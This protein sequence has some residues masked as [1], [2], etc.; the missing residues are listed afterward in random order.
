MGARKPIIHRGGNLA[1]KVHSIDLS[2]ESFTAY[3]WGERNAQTVLLAHATGFHARCWDGVVEHLPA[4]LNVIAIDARGH[5][6]STNAQPIE[7]HQFALDCVA[8]AKH[9]GVQG[10]IGVG[11][12]MGG[13]TVAHACA[14]DR[15]LFAGLVLVDPVIFAPELYADPPALFDTVEAH[16]IS[17][18]RSSFASWQALHERL[19]DRS[20]YTLWEADILRDYCQFGVVPS[21]SAS[22]ERRGVELACP[23][24][25]EAQ[26]Y[27]GNFR[28]NILP[29]LSK[30]DQHVKVLRAKARDFSGPEA[31]MDFSASPTWPE[32]AQHFGGQEMGIVEDIYLPELTHFIPM[33]APKLVADHI[34]DMLNK[35]NS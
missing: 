5:G 3:E 6:N 34:V 22:E 14:L 19:K 24:E 4:D 9:L 21:A 16:P 32:L 33:Q 30:I 20:P 10:A 17:R 27:V 11:H 8:I 28:S 18:R 2:G 15:S 29:L 23:P 13:Y 25:I 1:P 7:W 35:V 26:V 31:A 12:S